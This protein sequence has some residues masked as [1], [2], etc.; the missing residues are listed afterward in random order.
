MTKKH[1]LY[2]IME[3]LGIPKHGKVRDI[4]DYGEKVIF[5]ASDRISA[6]DYVM[7][8]LIPDKGK[9][10]TSISEWWFENTEHILPNHLISTSTKELPEKAQPHLDYLRGRSMVVTK[11]ITLPIEFI[12]RG[13]ITGGGWNEYKRTGAICGVALPEGLVKDSELETPIFTPS[14]KAESGHDENIDY[15][16]YSEILKNF[17]SAHGVTLDPDF[18]RDKVLELFEFGRQTLAKKG[19]LLADTKF[20][21]GLLQD[22]SV[23]LIDEALTPDSSRLWLATEWEPGDKRVNYDKQIL[24][25][26]L[27]SIGWDKSS[28]PPSLPREVIDKTR[29]K[30]IEAFQLITG[31]DFVS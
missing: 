7:P 5:I 29:E 19:L 31:K 9:I 30:Y 8:N 2:H 4:Y 24:R 23:I 18:L 3:G 22:G 1:E 28:S 6:Y 20:E 26:W 16:K 21:L 10:L 15:L 25:D 12:V 13:Y 27:E 11:A 17:S 14:T